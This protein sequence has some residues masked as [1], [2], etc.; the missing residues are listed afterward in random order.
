ML[1]D[2]EYLYISAYLEEDE[3]WATSG[4]TRYS[5]TTTEVFIDL[6]ETLTI[7]MNLK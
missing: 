5:A 4:A 2:D 6:M 7:T 1:W 3:I